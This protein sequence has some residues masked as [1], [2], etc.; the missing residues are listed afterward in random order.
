MSQLTTPFDMGGHQ[1]FLILHKN[2]WKEKRKRDTIEKEK[3]REKIGMKIYFSNKKLNT[4]SFNDKMSLSGIWTDF[5]D[6]CL[7]NETLY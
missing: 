5:N 2:Q 7:S 4:F 6:K 1:G 3:T